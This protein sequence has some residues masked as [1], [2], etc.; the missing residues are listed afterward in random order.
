MKVWV[1]EHGEY[2]QRGVSFVA[3]SMDAAFD[4]IIRRHPAPPNKI[5]WVLDREHER[6]VGVATEF[7]MGHHIAG[8]FIYDLTEH[9]VAK[10]K[11]KND[12]QL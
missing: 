4:E 6:V 10:V 8:E 7:V 1:V 9:D 2:E 5:E 11:S 12:S 3:A